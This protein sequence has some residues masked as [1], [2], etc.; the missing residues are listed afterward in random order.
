MQA[1]SLGLATKTIPYALKMADFITDE[2]TKM[3]N[4]RKDIPE[5]Y[6]ARHSRPQY[7]LLHER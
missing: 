6:Q 7:R 2:G 4:F 5:Q 3:Q 1:V